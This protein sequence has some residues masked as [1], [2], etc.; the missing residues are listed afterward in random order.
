MQY[1][2]DGIKGSVASDGELASRYVVGDGGWDADHGDTELPE[3]LSGV[4][5][6]PNWLERL[7]HTQII[8][9]HQQHPICNKTLA[10]YRY[11]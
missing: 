9:A 1:L 6:H 4:A 11:G 7:K 3:V 2:D 10:M 8:Q 5:Q